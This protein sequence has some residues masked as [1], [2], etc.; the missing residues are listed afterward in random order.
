MLAVQAFE[1]Q[2]TDPTNVQV[3]QTVGVSVM[4]VHRY[5]L[6]SFNERRDLPRTDSLGRRVAKR[7]SKAKSEATPAQPAHVRLVE[8]MPEAGPEGPAEGAE[9]SKTLAAELRSY[10]AQKD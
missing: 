8:D 2:G 9:P 3:A 1:L 6:T 5:R 4:T 7:R 10:L